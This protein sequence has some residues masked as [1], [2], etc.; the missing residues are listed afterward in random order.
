MS[1][2]LGLQG[3]LLLIIPALVFGA[4]AQ[5]LLGRWTTRWL[6]LIASVGWIAGG[7]IASEGIYGAETTEENLQPLLD[8]LLWDEALMGGLLVGAVSIAGTW[9]LTRGRAGHDVSHTG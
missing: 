5:L 3:L 2:D 8:G 9:L 4:A 1:I 7:L 6:W